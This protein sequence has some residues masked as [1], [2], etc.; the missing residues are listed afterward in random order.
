MIILWFIVNNIVEHKL[1]TNVVPLCLCS[2]QRSQHRTQAF[3]LTQRPLK[4]HTQTNIEHKLYLLLTYLPLRRHRDLR[5]TGLLLQHKIHTHTLLKGAVLIQIQTT[6][7]HSPPLSHLVVHTWTKHHQIDSHMM[8]RAP[9][10][11]IRCPSGLAH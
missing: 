9:F 7:Q 2:T 1:L 3:T 5:E 10:E 6:R 11:D 8:S 4:T